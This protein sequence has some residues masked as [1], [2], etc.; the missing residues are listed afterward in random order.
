MVPKRVLF[1]HTNRR[2]IHSLVNA[3]RSAP[4]AEM[5]GKGVYKF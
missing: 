3:K 4:P 1:I 2:V 5:K